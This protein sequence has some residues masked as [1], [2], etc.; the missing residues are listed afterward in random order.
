MTTEDEEV[1]QHPSFA[2]E[3]VYHAFNIGLQ[4]LVVIAVALALYAFTG[5]P[6]GTGESFDAFYQ[7]IHG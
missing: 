3:F 2:A 1:D 7:L 5:N 6:A 4:S